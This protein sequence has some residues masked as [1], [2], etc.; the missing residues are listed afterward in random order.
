MSRSNKL[1]ER[2]ATLES[3]LASAIF[4]EL[5]K[6]SDGKESKYITRHMGAWDAHTYSDPFIDSIEKLEREVISLR[7]KFGTPAH[8]YPLSLIEDWDFYGHTNDER[9]SIA[10][11]L[12]A[13]RRAE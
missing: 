3:E 13:A 1:N 6:I 5:A 4:A 10:R 12:I 7:T 11:R 8:A 2:L 9:R